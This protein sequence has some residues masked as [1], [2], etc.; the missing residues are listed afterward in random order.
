M[1]AANGGNRESLLGPRP[2]RR[3]CFSKH[4]ADAGCRNPALSSECETERLKLYSSS[5]L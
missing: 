1:T 5:F 2:A 4:E 3:K